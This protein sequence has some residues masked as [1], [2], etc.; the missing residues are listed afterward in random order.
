LSSLRY[1]QGGAWTQR[2]GM[3]SLFFAIAPDAPVMLNEVKH[4]A[5]E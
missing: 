2:R 1:V 3:K 4:L 5:C